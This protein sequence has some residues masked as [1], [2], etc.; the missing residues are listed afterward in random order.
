MILPKFFFLLY[1]FSVEMKMEKSFDY[2]KAK[3]E[4][5]MWRFTAPNPSPLKGNTKFKSYL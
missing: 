3:H 5:D 1:L 4:K 2:E